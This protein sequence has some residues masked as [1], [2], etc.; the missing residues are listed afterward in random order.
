MLTEAHAQGLVLKKD[1]RRSQLQWWRWS[2]CWLGIIH[3]RPGAP[4]T[5]QIEKNGATMLRG[6]YWTPVALRGLLVHLFHLGCLSS[7]R[8]PLWCIVIVLS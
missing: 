5:M 1:D 8:T 3:R 6:N 2:Q 4:A 7:S